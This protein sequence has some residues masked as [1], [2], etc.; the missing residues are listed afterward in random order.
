[1]THGI[2]LLCGMLAIALSLNSLPKRVPE[3]LFLICFLTIHCVVPFAFG[4]GRI[5]PAAPLAHLEAALAVA[6]TL[7]GFLLTRQFLRFLMLRDYDGDQAV[8][9]KKQRAGLE[10]I[11]L[12][13]VGLFSFIAAVYLTRGNVSIDIDRFAGRSESSFLSAALVNTGF[14]VLV[15]PWYYARESRYSIAGLIAVILLLFFTFAYPGTRLFIVYVVGSIVAGIILHV[16]TWRKILAI[17]LL[18][19]FFM[20]F[21]VIVTYQ[22]RRFAQYGY[23]EALQTGLV[24]I[25]TSEIPEP[26]DYHRQMI[27]AAEAF[28][29]PRDWFWG[30]S[31][32]RIAFAFVPEKFSFGLKPRDTNLRFA[33]AVDFRLGEQSVTIPPSVPGEGYI[34]FGLL[35]SVLSGAI[36]AVLFRFASRLWQSNSDLAFIV[37]PAIFGISVMSVRGQLYDI[38]FLV[39]IFS[40][41]GVAIIAIIRMIGWISYHG[42]RQLLRKV[43][44]PT[45]KRRLRLDL[46]TDETI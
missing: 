14:L 20:G 46:A 29:E 43:Q 17:L 16:K 25:S 18:S 33:E 27:I 4:P 36:Y 37:N 11:V 7:G 44:P 45:V 1:M 31:Y 8:R 10:A 41:V 35:G 15:A 21:F 32:L 24:S 12:S 38:V 26:L 22:A 2:A 28:Q 30:D 3:E 42:R 19:G 6:C 5:F 13:G 9:N 40:V 23:V 34:N 39:T